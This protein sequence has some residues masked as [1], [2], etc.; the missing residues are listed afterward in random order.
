MTSLSPRFRRSGFTLVELLVVI[1]II[2]VLIAL[3]LPAV[4]Q[5][6]EAARRMQCSNN[7]KQLGLAMHNYHDTYQAFPSGYIHVNVADNKGH[8]T[9]SAFILP[10][11]ELG[12]VSD[13]LQVGKVKASDALSAHQDVMQAKYDTFICPSDTGP[14][15]SSTS[16]CAGCAIE[17]ASGTNLGLSKTSYV[18]VNSSAYVRANQATNFGDG[19]TG[20]TGMFFKDSD[21]RMRDITD[22]TSNTLM[23]AER[24]YILNNEWFGSSELFAT[25]DKNAKGPDNHQHPD[26]ANYDQGLYRTLCTTLFSPNI[27]IGSTTSTNK[28]ENHGM[29]SMHPGGAMAVFADGSVSFLPETI[30]SNTTG[31]TD[32]VMEYLGNMQDGQVIGAY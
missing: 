20:A 27:T 17:N 23:V 15:V 3:L 13:V 14:S 16:K 31:T 5:A 28:A 22:G 19:T 1:A 30:H 18:A 24:A 2:G 29:S 21:T 6:R 32:T 9:W 10:F 25:R 7:L 11:M 12:N 26:K 8:W 4:Q